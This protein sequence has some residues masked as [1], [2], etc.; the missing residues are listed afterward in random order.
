MVVDLASTPI[1]VTIILGVVGLAIPVIDALKKERGYNNRL[2]SGIAFGAIAISIGFVI[3]RVASGEVLPAVEFSQDVLANDTFGSFF[4]IALLIV[5]LMVTASSWDY[6]KGKS[7]V[8]AYYS[9]ILLSSIGMVLI[10]YSTDLV[11]LFVSW[12]LMS[13]PTYALAAFSKRDPISNEAA[14]KYFMFGALSSGILVLAI[15]FVYGI[16]GTTNIGESIKALVI[17]DQNLIP[18]GLVATALFIAGF[19]FK[20]GLVPFHMWIPDAYEGSPT[21]IGALLSAGT[22]KAGFAAAIRVVVLGMFALNLDWTIT[23]AILAVFTMTIGNFGAL[24]QRSLPRILAYSSIAQAG[25]ILIGM[26]VAPYSDQALPGSLFQIFNHAIM[27]STGF[28]AAAAVATA[29]ASYGLEKYRGLGYRMPITAIALTISLL[30]LAGVPPLNGFWGKLVIFGAAIDSS[31]YVWWGPYLAIAGVL[32]SALS[33]GYYAWI[34]RKMY[35]ENGPDMSKVKEPKAMLAVLVFG[36]VFMVGF[37]VWY[38]P[39][40]EFAT[41][42][43]PD[44]TTIV[45]ATQLP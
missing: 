39:L 30:A 26:A 28:I 7:N 2:Y 4:A 19:G 45:N 34:I 44:F 25:Y 12:E 18:V 20:M 33:L 29:L 31:A 9:L 16:T 15:G 17:L 3:F 40:L 5:S 38:A 14:I 41:I 21:T 13:L 32:N 11:M 24:I 27:K 1:V 22:K 36:L 6:M 43:V 23:L 10:A 35:M 8:A 37:G 42:S